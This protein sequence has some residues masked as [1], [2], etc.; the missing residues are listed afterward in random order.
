MGAGIIIFLR[1]V[2]LINR[3]NS[4]IVQRLGY[5]AFTS[6]D[7]KHRKDP[8]SIP[9]T[10]NAF[11]FCYRDVFVNAVVVGCLRFAEAVSGV[12]GNEVSCPC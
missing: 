12:P 5:S 8:G 4:R 3:T 2:I 10:G 7:L 11:P 9:G 6:S 1:Q